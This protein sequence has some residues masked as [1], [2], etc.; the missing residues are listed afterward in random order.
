MGT[1]G[2]QNMDCDAALDIRADESEKLLKRIVELAGSEAATQFD[3]YDHDLLFYSFEALF[4]LD[5]H[6]LFSW[7]ECPTPE[8]A[9][10]LKVQ[11]LEGWSVYFDE[12]AGASAEFTAQRRQVIEATFDRFIAG[13]QAQRDARA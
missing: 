4:A 1:W 11:H 6:G 8:A 7:W 13:C 2:P 9:Q 12:G 5:T 10:A 3:E